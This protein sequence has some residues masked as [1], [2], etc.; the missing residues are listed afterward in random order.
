MTTTTRTA[1]LRRQ[2]SR[3]TRRW[4]VVLA[5]MASA[6]ALWGVENSL[7]GIDLAVRQGDRTHHIYSLAVTLTS[8]LVGLL[9]WGSLTLLERWSVRGRSIWIAVA[10]L[11]LIVSFTGPASAA[12]TS[13]MLGLLAMHLVVGGLLLLALAPAARSRRRGR[14]PAA[15]GA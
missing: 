1:T 2:R 5:A 9:A 14:R 10:A 3:H 15:S 8:L 4:F 12:S 7:L 11:V 13:A 6:T